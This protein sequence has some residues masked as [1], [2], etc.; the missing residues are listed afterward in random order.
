VSECRSKFPVAADADFKIARPYDAVLVDAPGKQYSNRTSYVI[1]REGKIVYSYSALDPDKH[2][3]KTLD[4][5]TKL[6][7]APAP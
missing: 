6:K 5:L 7:A 3:A 2:V 1:S 4:A